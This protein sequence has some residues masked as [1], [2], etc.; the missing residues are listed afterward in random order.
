MA[1]YINR[2]IHKTISLIISARIYVSRTVNYAY[3][4]NFRFL[5]SFFWRPLKF[6]NEQRWRQ[7]YS[8][9][10]FFLIVKQFNAA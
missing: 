7:S 8:S 5:I 6:L 9:V 3:I 2:G 1:K 10:I 4:T